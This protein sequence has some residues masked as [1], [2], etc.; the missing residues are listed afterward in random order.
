MSMKHLY[1]FSY[2]LM[3]FKKLRASSCKPQAA[4][5]LRRSMLFLVVFIVG[6]MALQAQ[7]YPLFTNYLL[8]QYGFNPATTGMATDLQVNLYYRK[9]WT[10][11]PDAPVTRIA[12]V[13]SR[14]RRVPF[15]VGGYF[16][17]DEAGALRRSGGTLML[18][19]T[20]RIG[21]KTTISA[22]FAGGFHQLRL[23]DDF[24]VRDLDDPVILN[25]QTGLWAPDFNAGL[26]VQSGDFYFGFS[27]PQLFEPR[28]RFGD[29]GRLSRLESH[30]YM[31]AGYDWSLSEH[32]RLEPSVMLKMTEGI[33]IQ[34]EAALRGIF[35][36]RYWVGGLYRSQEAL[37]AMA[38][39]A[40]GRM[41]EVSYSYDFT[42]SGLRHANSGSHEISLVFRFERQKHDRDND[43][44]A[45]KDDKCPDTS[46]PER[47]G[48][49]PEDI[50]A[51]KGVSDRDADEIPDHLDL[52]PDVPG[53]PDNNGC[54]W[55][56]RDGDGIPDHQDDCPGI[57]GVAMNNGC[58]VNDRDA[59]GIIDQ[60][61]QCPDV[62]GSFVNRGCP[63]ADNDHDGT[64]D[65]LDKCPGT[66]GPASNQ[67]CP[68]VTPEESSLLELAVRSLYFQSAQV[69]IWQQSSPHL[70][71][72]AELM[73]N[74][75]DWRLRIAGHTDNKGAERT[76]LLLSKDR[77]ESVYNFMLS[78]GVRRE[79]L[80][81]EYF[82]SAKPFADNNTEAGRQ[83]NRRVEL[84]FVFD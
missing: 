61:D 16:F 69:Q 26:H 74:R 1:L 13:R 67:G 60:F 23:M 31:V 37:A 47:N 41:L 36:N 27:I 55:G 44:V 18:S 51:E 33:P 46:G 63:D 81:M 50:F 79:Q 5:R 19:Y 83:L 9:Q 21:E 4:S 14:L 15:A 17:K 7:Q 62:P 71:R 10:G 20:Q 64:P 3:I 84:E 65:P 48:G 68:V 72:L 59:D 2:L 35:M 76:N 22:G 70:E 39:F 25:A 56:D 53:P 57:V 66:F 52:C 73:K 24:T 30:Y 77:A 8:N 42:T 78:K 34:P 12:A 80:V 45:D 29:P 6:S 43:G 11:F 54:P 75:S 38:G 40:A 28:L 58:P 82:G 32:F 49:C